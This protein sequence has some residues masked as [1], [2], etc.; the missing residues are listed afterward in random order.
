MP[1]PF[2]NYAELARVG[3]VTRGRM[4]QILRLLHLAPDIQERLL[5]SPSATGGELH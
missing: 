2:C 1:G 4:T 5:F 3:R